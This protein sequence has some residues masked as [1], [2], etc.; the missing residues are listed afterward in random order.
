M[1]LCAALEAKRRQPQRRI[2]IVDRTTIGA[3]ASRHAPGIQVAVG[4]TE[5]ERDLARRGLRGWDRLFPAAS[6]PVGRSCE[7][8]WIASNVASLRSWHVANGPTPSDCGR[9]QARLSGLALAS[10]PHDRAILADRCSYSPVIHIVEELSRRLT[11]MGC[12]IHE[13]FEVVD[14]ITDNVAVKLHGRDGRMLQ[15]RQVIVAIGPWLPGFRTLDKALL[16]SPPRV[17]KI[18]AFHLDRKP[19]PDCPAIALQEDYAFLI[20][21][22]EYG[23]WLFSFTSPHW[24]VRPVAS[25]LGVDEADLA[26]GMAIL[27]KWFPTDTPAILSTRVFCDCYPADG[28]PF[29]AAHRTSGNVVFL[30]GGSGNGFRFAPPCA[31]DA[32]G[33]LWRSDSETESTGRGALHRIRGQSP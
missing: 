11:A 31:E 24:D 18:V 4:R 14:I 29:V 27:K 22:I 28:L 17:K 21:M 23:Y 8:F 19:T 2:S 20:P 26:T 7:L 12:E 32:I 13:E 3:G 6:W 5:A 1:G 16:P 9:L 30:G 25:T 33:A 15:S 10:I